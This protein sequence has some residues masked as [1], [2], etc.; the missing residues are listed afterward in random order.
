[1]ETTIFLA[2]LWGPALLAVGLGIFVSRKYYVRVYHE[3]EKETLAMLCFGMMAISVGIAQIHFHNVWSTFPQIIV[4]LLGWATLIKGFAM[5][6]VPG[7]VD[8]GGDWTVKSKLLPIS[9][10]LT[11]ILGL[12]LSWLGY[13]A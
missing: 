4:S 3:L 12:Y 5:T 6:I 8:R 2:Q 11:V 10:A 13:L 9:G 1:M 7:F